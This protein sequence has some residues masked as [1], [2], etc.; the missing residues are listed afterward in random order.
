M[1]TR[2]FFNQKLKVVRY[3]TFELYNPAF[4]VEYYVI[5]QFFDKGFGIEPT[6]TRNPSTNQ[7]FTAI[8]GN[9]VAPQISDD[10]VIQLKV[11]L[12]RVGSLVKAKL[13]LL[14]GINRIEPTEFIYRQ[15]LS[16]DLTQPAAT[17]LQLYVGGVTIDMDNVGM[18]A[19]ESNPQTVTVAELYTAERFP[20]LRDVGIA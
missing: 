12:G 19:D 3:Q 8:S 13:K 5:D 10:P 6:A 17:P 20:G 2:T 4:G 11:S 15:Y 7:T 18:T 9:I 16:T 1:P 14:R